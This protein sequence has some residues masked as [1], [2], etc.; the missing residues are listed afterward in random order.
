MKAVIEIRRA[1][2]R[3]GFIAESVYVLL[4][5]LWYWEPVERFKQRNDV[6]S[7]TFFQ[8]QASS[9]VLYATKAMDRGSR[10]AR[11]ERIA[12]VEARQIERGDLFHCSLGGKIL[13]DRTN[14]TELVAA[15][16][17]GLTNEV[18]HGECA[19]EENAEAFDR[20]RERDC[21]IIKLNGVDGNGGQFLSCSDEHRFCLVT[22]KLKFVLCHTDFY[23]A[24][25]ARCV[26]LQ[27][28]GKRYSLK[29]IRT[30]KEK[31]RKLFPS[32]RTCLG[33]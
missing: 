12:V 1:S 15:G 8:Y 25:L 32:D 2:A 27:L 17:G 24:D 6:V 16:F 11:K 23:E 21:D 29:A 28:A 19:V 4:R 5:F 9:T 13:P 7:L 3:G 22:V 33:A 20:V 14:S 10:Q 30:L 18:L 26:I 31:R